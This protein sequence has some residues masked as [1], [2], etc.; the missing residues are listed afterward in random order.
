MA[1]PVDFAPSINAPVKARGENEVFPN[2]FE[3]AVRYG[4]LERDI[5][6]SI[7][8]NTYAWP[9]YMIFEIAD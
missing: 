9:N 8:N 2:S 5:V 7:Y 4:L 6:A 1:L 3:A